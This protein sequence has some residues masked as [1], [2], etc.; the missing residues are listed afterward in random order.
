MY[1]ALI[2]DDEPVVRL[3]TMRALTRVGFACEPAANGTEALL[4]VKESKFDVVVTD[5]R[6]PQ[7]NGH[8]L[9]V[10][11]LA[12]AQR[13]AVVV[14]TGAVDPRLAKD[15]MTRG[16]DE[17][18]HKPIEYAAFATQV[19]EIADARALRRKTA[20]S[21]SV[22]QLEC[23]PVV[24]QPQDQN[25]SDCLSAATNKLPQPPDQFDG[26]RRATDNAV[27]VDSLMTAIQTDPHLAEAVLRLANSVQYSTSKQI[28]ELEQAL[29]DVVGKGQL[30]ARIGVGLA[31]AVGAM[32]GWC[33]QWLASAL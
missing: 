7:M 12:L 21:P 17:V 13:P 32:S 30:N 10:E 4:R 31:L 19:K 5:L 6:M 27:G 29:L 2:V 24:A 22:P 16:V 9:A 28:A 14:L 8:C 33:L 3:A 18:C 15:L 26:F 20:P 1:R 25:F 23:L 11:L